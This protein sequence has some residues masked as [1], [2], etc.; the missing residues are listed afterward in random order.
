LIGV[1]LVIALYPDAVMTAD[2]AVVPHHDADR[3]SRRIDE[4]R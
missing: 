4:S 2:D 3:A 1:G